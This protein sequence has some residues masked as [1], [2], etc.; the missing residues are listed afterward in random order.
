M[1][2]NM[3]NVLLAAC[4]VVTR[5]AVAAQHG[6]GFSHY[7]YVYENVLLRQSS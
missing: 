7:G 3:L 2:K 4:F 6:V 5:L 1:I